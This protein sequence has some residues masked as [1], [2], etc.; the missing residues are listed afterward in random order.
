MRIRIRFL[1]YIRLSALQN[2]WLRYL[3]YGEL[4]NNS[5]F[6]IM[7]DVRRILLAFD[8]TRI[9]LW[10]ILASVLASILVVRSLGKARSGVR[11]PPTLPAQTPIPYIGHAVGLMRKR[12][13]YFSDL[14]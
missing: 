2:V 1:V 14:G 4:L 11:K 3:H 10:G 7:S 8:T 12:M 6:F 9:A 13:D 5:A